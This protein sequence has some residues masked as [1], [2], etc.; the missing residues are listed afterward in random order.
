MAKYNLR[1]GELGG[2]RSAHALECVINSR[3]VEAERIAEGRYK[4]W[5]LWERNHDPKLLKKG[6]LSCRNKFHYY[7]TDNAEEYQRLGG[8]DGNFAILTKRREAAE[9]EGC[10]KSSE[11]WSFVGLNSEEA[12][13]PESDVFNMKM[14]FMPCS[15]V[16]CRHS[17]EYSLGLSLGPVH[18]CRYQEERMIVDTTVKRF[19]HPGVIPDNEMIQ[20]LEGKRSARDLKF[21]LRSRHLAVSYTIAK[22]REILTEY[23]EK[24]LA[25]AAATA[26]AAVLAAT[27]AVAA[28][29]VPPA[30]AIP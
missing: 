16:N 5:A 18:P 7:V 30:V 13:D 4:D 3:K 22:S 9:A 26:A 21:Q 6:P 1:V 8:A 11:C 29:R 12:H 15:C 17:R 27:S 14:A 25:E 23:V 19:M 2:I 24:T 20:W 10:K 28:G